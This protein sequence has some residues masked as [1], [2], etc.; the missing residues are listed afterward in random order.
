MKRVKDWLPLTL[1]TAALITIVTFAWPWSPFS[2][3]EDL[4]AEV[5]ARIGLEAKID[6][7]TKVVELEA[8]ISSE[9][10]QSVDYKDAVRELR[11]LRRVRL[12]EE[13]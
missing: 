5:R 1:A 6:R 9:P 11:H 2:I 12:A 7:L 13:K 3:R 8:T 4:A 10:Q